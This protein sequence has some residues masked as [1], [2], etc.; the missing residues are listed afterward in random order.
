MIM[1][2]WEKWSIWKSSCKIL[3]I[4][5]KQDFQKSAILQVIQ[6]NSS[7]APIVTPTSQVK[8]NI[9]DEFFF[10]TKDPKDSEKSLNSKTTIENPEE[11]KNNYLW[12]SKD[13]KDFGGCSPSF[14]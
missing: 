9:A 3:T 14:V 7:L 5:V 2:F 13:D 11:E 6:N 10:S 4:L 12:N 8:V 1:K